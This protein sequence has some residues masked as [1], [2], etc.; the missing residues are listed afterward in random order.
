MKIHLNTITLLQPINPW[1]FPW[2]SKENRVSQSSQSRS[3]EVV[4]RTFCQ[5]LL[6]AWRKPPRVTLPPR[7]EVEKSASLPEVVCS[8]PPCSW[9]P[10]QYSPRGDQSAC[11]AFRNAIVNAQR[12]QLYSSLSPLFRDI[13]CVMNGL[14]TV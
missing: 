1:P 4:V 9:L 13:L 8:L 10:P 5:H 3:N 12:C 11:E 14:S 2:W 7:T 6:Q